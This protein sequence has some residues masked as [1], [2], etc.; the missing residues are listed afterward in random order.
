MV[1]VALPFGYTHNALPASASRCSR[2]MI[3]VFHMLNGLFSTSGAM[4]VGR[5]SYGAFAFGVVR[6]GGGMIWWSSGA[7]AFS[8]DQAGARQAVVKKPLVL[9]EQGQRPIPGGKRCRLEPGRGMCVTTRQPW[10]PWFRPVETRRQH[11]K[12]WPSVW[13]R[14]DS[15]GTSRWK[16]D[17]SSTTKRWPQSVAVPIIALQTAIKQCDPGGNP[18][19]RTA[20]RCLPRR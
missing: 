8:G 17:G 3:G 20:T 6:C 12:R 13:P 5:R 7:V 15:K 2:V 18:T 19:R 16:I 11:E 1:R 4:L 9:N 14:R 10:R